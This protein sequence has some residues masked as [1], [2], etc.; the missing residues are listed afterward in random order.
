M[1]S[2]Y[3]SSPAWQALDE[4][5]VVCY[6]TVQAWT[7]LQNATYGHASHVCRF[8]IPSDDAYYIPMTVH[9]V[10]CSTLSVT[11]QLKGTHA[12][13]Y[14]PALVNSDPSMHIQAASGDWVN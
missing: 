5:P 4:A 1:C 9:V 8:Q 7:S 11:Y 6:A 14:F 2:R 10:Y 13:A 12:Y 3:T